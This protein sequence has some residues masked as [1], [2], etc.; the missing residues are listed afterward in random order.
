MSRYFRNKYYEGDERPWL[1]EKRKVVSIRLSDKEIEMVKSAY[2]EE[3][4]SY[5]IRSLIHKN[6]KI[7][8]SGIL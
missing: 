7:D 6:I 3:D 4:L 1:R 2:P 5:G 8:A